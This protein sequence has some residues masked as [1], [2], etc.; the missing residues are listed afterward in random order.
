MLS[1]RADDVTIIDLTVTR[2][3]YHGLHIR[4]QAGN[5]SH[6]LRPVIYNVRVIDNAQQQIKVNQE[7]G[8]YVDHG[9]LACSHLE[10]TNAG[11][12]HVRDNCYTG[13]L[14]A[15]KTRGWHI[16]DNYIAGMWC[17]AGLSEHGIHMWRTNADTLIERNLLV[18]C[19]RA[20]GLGMANR[21]A[22]NGQPD[23]TFDDIECPAMGHV[24]DYTATVINNV[25]VDTDPRVYQSQG[26]VDSGIALWSAC[27]AKVFHNTIYRSQNAFSSIEAR[28]SGTHA[29]IKNNLMTKAVRDREAGH[30]D[31]AG[32]VEM[33]A[34]DVYVD[35]PMNDFH[36]DARAAFI[37]T[38]VPL[39]DGVVPTDMDG[40]LRDDQPDPGAFELGD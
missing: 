18:D 22:N 5:G 31:S 39:G 15:H 9:Q 27:G 14:D 37:N 32:N 24:D 11:R 19:V 35:A 20:I 2:G 40:R 26:G 8:R 12:P 28:W 13:G 33:V 1:I 3:Y 30:I 7:G 4:P 10:L 6:V 36:L 23:R 38:G 34:A 17:E 16:R 21:P 29:V 25:I